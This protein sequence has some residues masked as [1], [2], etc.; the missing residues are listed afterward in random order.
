MAN[1]ADEIPGASVGP[2]VIIGR[3]PKRTVLMNGMTP[4]VGGDQFFNDKSPLPIAN[5]AGAPITY[6]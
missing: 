6:K 5:P 2:E 1:L 4:Y 3:R